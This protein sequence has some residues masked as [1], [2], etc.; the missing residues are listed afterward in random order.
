MGFFF[1]AAALA[2]MTTSSTSASRS[3]EFASATANPAWRAE[4]P[5]TQNLTYL[6]HAAVA[7]LSRRAR[8]AM[9]AFLAEA[10]EYGAWSGE[11]WMAGYQACRQSLAQLL[12]ARAEDIAL[13]KNT[14]E[15]MATVALGLDWRPGDRI[16]TAACEFPANIYP[17]LAL[18]ERGVQVEFVPHSPLGVDLGALRR[19]ARG[20]KLVALS[21]VQYLSGARLDVAAVGQICRETGALFFLDAIQGLGA[22]PVRAAESGVH[23]LAADGHKWLAGPEGAAVFYVHPEALPLLTPRM[24]GWMSVAPW[25]DF[26]A[27]AR[28][29]YAGAGQPGAPLPWQKDA[30][31]FECGTLNTL[32]LRGLAAAVD[33]LLEVGGEKIERQILALTRQL[34]AGLRERGA[35]ILG[36]RGD[37]DAPEAACSGIVSFRLPGQASPVLLARLRSANICCAERQGYIRCAPHFYNSPEEI[38]HVLAALG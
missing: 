1:P 29:A 2:V 27:A 31:R 32:G 17:W 13:L 3:T 18:R 5:V 8:Q 34:A 37:P 33:L 16:V 24:V 35:E 23:F 36:P 20:A 10:T 14:T 4:F 22:F 25:A 9:A 30:S 15:G 26:S 19:Q 6:N 11:T 12:A 28:L 7:P 21:F 38:G